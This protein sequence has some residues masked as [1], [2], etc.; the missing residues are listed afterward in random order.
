MLMAMLLHHLVAAQTV[1]TVPFASSGN[2]IELAVANTS[3]MRSAECGVRIKNAP[4]WLRFTSKEQT[5]GSIEAGEEELATFVFSVD[6]SAPVGKEQALKFVISNAKGERW[7]KAI[8]IVV[9]APERFELFQNYPN[10]FNPTTTISYQLPVKAHVSLKVY[11]LLGQE[12]ATLV[13]SEQPAGYHQETFDARTLSSGLY[14]YQLSLSG[15]RDNRTLAR[16][17]MLLLK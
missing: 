3:G 8:R 14:V 17:T 2:T 7:T 9:S 5:I 6:Q 12:V 15:V 1:H 13:N 16:R 4:A 11:N 10:P